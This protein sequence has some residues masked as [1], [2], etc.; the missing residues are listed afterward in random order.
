MAD[1]AGFLAAFGLRVDPQGHERV[2]HVAC[3]L[4][5]LAFA[6]RKEAHAIE[7]GDAAMREETRRATRLFLQDHLGRFFPAFAQ[8]LRSA[9]GERFHGSLAALGT[10]FVASEC[11]RFGVATG[12]ETLRLR[13]PIE[14]MAPMACGS[15]DGCAPGA[16]PTDERE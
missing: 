15:A 16:C 4:E 5:F 8:R 13:L 6:T 14:D 9:D 7:T 10:A 11:A 2:D 12:P 1:L 3:E